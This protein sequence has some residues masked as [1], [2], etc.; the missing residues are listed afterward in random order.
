MQ[1]T[2]QHQYFGGKMPVAVRGMN[3]IK[4]ANV[5][6]SAAQLHWCKSVSSTNILV[7]YKQIQN[8]ICTSPFWLNDAYSFCGQIKRQKNIDLLN[9]RQEPSICHLPV[10]PPFFLIGY[11]TFN[12]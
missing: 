6:M 1:K 2:W 4:F 12:V 8:V 5:F 9:A 3:I 11:I 7:H 10:H